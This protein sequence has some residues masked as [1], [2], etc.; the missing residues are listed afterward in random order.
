MGTMVIPF[1]ESR[2]ELGERS[3][4][5]SSLGSREAAFQAANAAVRKKA[6][7]TVV[8]DVKEVT[9]LAD[10]FVFTGGESKAQ[11][12]AIVDEIAYTFSQ[13]GRKPKAMEGVTE[14]RWVLLDFGDVIIHIL[15]EKERDYYKLEQFWNQGLVVAETE[16]SEDMQSD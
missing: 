12:K 8:L 6:K 16:W 5:S 4:T 14:G 13:S 11:V 7:S 2:T 15:Q 10:Y 1:I 3:V 9:L